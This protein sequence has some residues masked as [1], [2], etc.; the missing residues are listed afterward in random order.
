M[1]IN[2][3]LDRFKKNIEIDLY[4][5]TIWQSIPILTSTASEIQIIPF[6]LKLN[7]RILLPSVA[8][9]ICNLHEFAVKMY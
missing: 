5:N 3:R 2:K 8:I 7:A 9:E 1:L 4:C 6:S